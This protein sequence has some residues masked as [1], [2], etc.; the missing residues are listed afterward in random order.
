MVE[1]AYFVGLK[2]VSNT[3]FKPHAHSKLKSLC[4]PLACSPP[5]VAM[6]KR[7]RKKINQEGKD[8]THIS[9]G[10]SRR[11]GEAGQGEGEAPASLSSSFAHPPPFFSL[12]SPVSCM[13]QQMYECLDGLAKHSPRFISV[14]QSCILFSSPC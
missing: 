8:N 13:Q 12:P 4:S 1:E 3:V 11:M 7:H 2:L 6:Q 9:C 10:P 5:G 14:G